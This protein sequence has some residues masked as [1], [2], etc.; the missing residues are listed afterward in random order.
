MKPCQMENG[1]NNWDDLL[2]KANKFHLQLKLT[3]SSST[4]FLDA[5]Q[6]IADMATTTRGGTKEIGSAL[7]RLCLRNRSVEAKLK[8]LT[9]SLFDS[10]ISPLQDR[11]DEW[12]KII[13]QID[14]EHSKEI[15]RLK[16][17]RKK[18]S[19]E[20]R[21]TS[22]FANNTF[23]M[24][25]HL[26]RGKLKNDFPRIGSM[27]DVDKIIESVDCNN[28]EKYFML[29]EVERNYVRRAL[30]EERLHYCVFFNLLRPVIEEELSM[31]QEIIHLEEILT[32]LTS[33]TND[34]HKLPTS[35]ENFIHS[36]QFND[37]IVPILESTY[38]DYG[39]H[40]NQHHHSRKSSISSMD[41][42]NTLSTDS[43]SF[44]NVKSLSQPNIIPGFRP[45]SIASQDSGF[46]SHD[47]NIPNIGRLVIY[48]GVNKIDKNLNSVDKDRICLMN[49]KSILCSS[50]TTTTTIES[51]DNKEIEEKIEYATSAPLYQSNNICSQPIYVNVHNDNNNGYDRT[52]F[53][54][55]GSLTPTNHNH[56][57]HPID[58]SNY[59]K[60]FTN[61][62]NNSNNL[63]QQTNVESNQQTYK[64]PIPPKPPLRHSSKLS[65]KYMTPDTNK[66]STLIFVK[67]T[68]N[69]DFPPP[70]PEAFIRPP[71]A[72]A[73]EQC[74]KI[75]DNLCCRYSVPN[76]HLVFCDNKECLKDYNQT[77]RQTYVPPAIYHSTSMMNSN[78]Q[79]QS[80]SA[81]GQD[82]SLTIQGYHK[83]NDTQYDNNNHHHH[84]YQ[85]S[86]NL[87]K[88]H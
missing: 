80:S 31:L 10:F 72:A 61:N 73:A 18:H 65:T 57:I 70:P 21:V 4:A 75:N 36:L 58:N 15:K 19:S 11:V 8:S 3:I 56:D 12:K 53:S 6:K 59:S 30:I 86:I 25:K 74:E 46:L 83:D 5:F 13:S 82:S 60:Y 33:L 2:L 27:Y 67:N 32:T 78:Q 62:V 55:E 44:R 79:Q 1:A 35:S 42:L 84:H 87:S 20:M 50:T 16:Q 54:S 66:R 26:P 14:K 52:R 69:S 34:P 41:S 51:N 88:N 49:G 76:R 47:Y 48:N 81:I 9:S 63:Q 24:R 22:A 39:S 71:A 17:F 37:S 28:K 7:T 40:H 68:E 43:V 23:R 64:K 85:S 45:K 29:E 38:S 77:I